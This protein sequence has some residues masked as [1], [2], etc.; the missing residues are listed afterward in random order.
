MAMMFRGLGKP[1]DQLDIQLAQPSDKFGVYGQYGDYSMNAAP[2]AAP[3]AK[4]GLGL[5]D[6]IGI[7]GEALGGAVGRGPGVYTQMK[8]QDRERQRQLQQA[9]TDRQQAMEDWT[10]KQ[11]WERQN[12]APINNDTVNDYNFYASKFGTEYADQYLKDKNDPVVNIPLPGGQV[13]IGPRSRLDAALKGGG[14]ASG[15]TPG[16][17]PP[18]TLPADFNFGGPTP[19]A[20]GTFPR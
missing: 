17:S 15:V 3:A 9:Q 13:F 2:T 19:P 10:A 20:S 7:A 14:Q 18:A 11:I 4:Q 8:L 12:P 5:R 6:I 16:G 1:T